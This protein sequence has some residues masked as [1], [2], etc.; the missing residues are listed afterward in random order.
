VLQRGQGP[1]P[2]LKIVGLTCGLLLQE[3]L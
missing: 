3:A 1:L 2:D